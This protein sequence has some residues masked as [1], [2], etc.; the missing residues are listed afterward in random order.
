MGLKTE[1]LIHM[2]SPWRGFN[3]TDTPYQSEQASA[4]Q[5]VG[6]LFGVFLTELI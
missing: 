5:E 1:P 6:L 3:G 2:M 4:G